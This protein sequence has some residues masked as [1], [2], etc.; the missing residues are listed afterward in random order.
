MIKKVLAVA[1]LGLFLSACGYHTCPTYAEKA[2]VNQEN[3]DLN[4]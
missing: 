3:K 4:V 2:P 1:L